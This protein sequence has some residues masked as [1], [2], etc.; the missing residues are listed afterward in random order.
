MGTGEAREQR[1]EN[2]DQGPP[3][4]SAAKVPTFR[5]LIVWQRA[6]ELSLAIYELTRQFPRD[7]LYGLSSQLRRAAVSIMSN[8][9]EGHG[10]GSVPQLMHFLLIAR[11]STFEV[12]SQLILASDLGLA[13]TGAI[14]RC[15]CLCD[16]VGRM[17]FATLSTLRSKQRETATKTIL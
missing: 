5:D 4:L 8:I 16:E 6:R 17:L 7:E 12:Q 3:I 1:T 11:G 15:E 14:S 10:R 9:A 2:R 13:D